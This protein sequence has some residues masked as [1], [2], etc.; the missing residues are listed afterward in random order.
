MEIRF[1][2][3]ALVDLE[4]L[5]TYLKDLSP[6][7]LQNVTD[8]IERTVYGIPDS[9]ARGR[10]TSRDD[11][12][13]KLTPKYKYLIPYTLRDNILY[14]LRVYHPSRKPLDYG[15]DPLIID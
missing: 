3:P 14:V 5:R 2:T 4:E 12:F 15:N 7:G 8:E 9:I 6:Q 1:S 11:V 10:R 13:E